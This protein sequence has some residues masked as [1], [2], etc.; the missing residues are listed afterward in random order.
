MRT[1][2]I[3]D[4]MSSPVIAVS[5]TTSL[6]K[7]NAL[8]REQHIRRLPVMSGNRL[9]GMVTFGDIRS[10]MPSDATT[11]SVY[12]LAYLMEQVTAAEIMRGDVIT[13]GADASVA[14]AA[15][16]ML[17]HKISGMPVMEQGQLVGI[18]TESDIF[19]VISSGLVAVAERPGNTV[20]APSRQWRTRV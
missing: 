5:P 11:L 12:E 13:I 4:V 18:I 8:M 17:E 20:A 10:A 19:R 9:V 14:E 3:R 7:L 6:P 16:R 1:L 15:Q 2:A